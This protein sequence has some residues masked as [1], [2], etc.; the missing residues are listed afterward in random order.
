M[1]MMIGVIVM[2]MTIMIIE[3][4]HDETIFKFPDHHFYHKWAVLTDPDD[5]AGGP[6]GYVKCDIA[7]FGKGDKIRVVE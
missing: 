6:K 5:I 7:V 2:M 3:N 1:T 4:M